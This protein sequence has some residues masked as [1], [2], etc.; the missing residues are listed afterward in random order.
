[1]SQTWQKFSPE[2]RRQAVEQMKRCDNVSE[3]ARQLGIRRKWLYKWKE[4]LGGEPPAPRPPKRTKEEL[5][6]ARVRELEALAGRQ[7]LELDFFKGAL[8][9]IEER[10]RKR[11]E[12]S[13]PASTN[14]S[15]L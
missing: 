6:A 9:R 7:A 8:R 10:Q 1:L 15:E 13:G 2:F 11:G 3:L 5:L 4:E 12:T 14:K